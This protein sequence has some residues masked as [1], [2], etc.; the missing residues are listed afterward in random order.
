MANGDPFDGLHEFLAIAR[1]G[2]IRGAAAELG[3]TPGAVSQALQGLERRLGL[4]LFHRTTR[5]ISLTEAGETLLGR[6]GPAADAITGTID[7]L[8]RMTAEPSGTLRL[9]A[10]RMAVETVIHPLIPAFRA[11]CPGVTVDITIDDGLEDQIAGRYDAHI[12]IGEFIDRDMIAVRVSRPFRWLVAASPDYLARRGRPE[13]PED[14]ARHDCIRFRLA[15][16]RRIYR[17]EFERPG[18]DGTAQALSVDPPGDIVT[19][20]TK[21][22]RTFALQGLGLV[23]GSELMLAE[24]LAA[25][26]LET[27]LDAFMPARDALFLCY[28]RASR[29]DP[30]L[31]AFVEACQRQLRR[32]GG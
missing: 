6:L 31:R 30:K 29:S 20:D 8:R 14:I 21:L 2:S 23:Y 11:A 25:G 3:V 24:D 17:W 13:V 1:R 7:G 19:N 16:S 32:S 22:V 26:R 4:P 28:P 15:R 10:H 27:V 12:A 18:P 5:R 9:L